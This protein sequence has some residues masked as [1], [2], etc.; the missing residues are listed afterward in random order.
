MPIKTNNIT[1]LIFIVLFGGLAYILNNEKVSISRSDR[2]DFSIDDSSKVVQITLSSKVPE[3][4]ILRRVNES[5]WTIN[6]EYKAGNSLVQNLLKTLQRMEIA[7]PVPLTMR[8]NILGNLAI[9]GIR[10]QVELKNGDEKIFYVGGENR[11]Q[12]ATFMMLQNAS[13]PYAVHIPGFQGYLSSRFFTEEYIWRDKM[14]MNY[15]NKNIESIMM[16]YM[17]SNTAES[18]CIQ[19]NN[20]GIKVFEKNSGKIVATKE[21]KVKRFLASFRKLPAESFV[22]GNLN[23]DSLLKTKP[24]FE[25]SVT[26]LEGEKTSMRV[27]PKRNLN[28]VNIEDNIIMPDPERL[29]AYVNE[30]DWMVIQLN[31]FN[32]IM[33]KLSDLKK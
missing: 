18:F 28:T 24:L 8:E 33:V 30:E 20:E 13:E 1:Y 4:A 32:K 12:S 2:R 11:E 31:S 17:D 3:T 9:Y 22:S 10:V 14:I 27:Y 16:N 19:Q 5:Y 29:Y 25:I 6:E 7:H 15:D 26:P 23:T 21:K